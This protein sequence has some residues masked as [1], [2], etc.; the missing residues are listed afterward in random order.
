MK[1]LVES[2]S[3][4]ATTTT[5]QILGEIQL[6]FEQAYG[7]SFTDSLATCLGS[8]LQIK[9]TAADNKKLKRKLRRECRDHISAQLQE[10]DALTVLAEGQSIAS[11]KRMRFSQSFE[12][13]E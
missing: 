4:S 9:P 7:K 8:G 10:N 6:V 12:T 11:Y 1:K 13:P 3:N 2:N 5:K